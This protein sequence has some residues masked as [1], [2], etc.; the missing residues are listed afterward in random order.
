MEHRARSPW[1]SAS[2]AAS[3][4]AS[5]TSRADSSLS[6]M[7]FSSSMRS[8]PAKIDHTP[9]SMRL[10]ATMVTFS[11]TM[12]PRVPASLMLLHWQSE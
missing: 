10:E 9:V 12:A 3:R 1:L 4:R 11:T 7:P 2:W 8:A 6:S 5:R